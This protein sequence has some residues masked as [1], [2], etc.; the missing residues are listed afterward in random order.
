VR[1]EYGPGLPELWEIREN[2]TSNLSKA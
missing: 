2:K 1:V